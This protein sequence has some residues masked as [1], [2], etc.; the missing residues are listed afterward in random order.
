[1][2]PARILSSSC[3]NLQSFDQEEE[4]TQNHDQKTCRMF[5]TNQRS[6]FQKNE[7]NGKNFEIKNS[8][9]FLPS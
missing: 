8:E 7:E 6:N 2:A 9:R 5:G 4:D 1:M 3:R